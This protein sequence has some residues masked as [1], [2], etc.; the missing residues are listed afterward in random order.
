MQ[1]Q[2]FKPGAHAAALTPQVLAHSATIYNPK[3]HETPLAI[4]HPQ[5][6]A[7]AHGWVN[8]L[9]FDESS[10]TL[11]ADPTQV[12]ENFTG[13]VK[14]G[15][16]KKI[17]ARFALTL[18]GYYPVIRKITT[19]LHQLPDRDRTESVPYGDGKPN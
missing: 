8:A 6:D 19:I 3:T 2:I 5:H 4:G 9:N 17:S 1:L 12:A 7:P 14:A 10:Q 11:L 18:A 13:A 15:Q 16:F